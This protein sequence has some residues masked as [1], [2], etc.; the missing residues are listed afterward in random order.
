MEYTPTQVKNLITEWVRDRHMI[1][2]FMTVEGNVPSMISVPSV[3]G[4]IALYT[5]K[6]VLRSIQIYI[7]ADI[8]TGQAA[9]YSIA[10][11]VG[12]MDF[13]TASEFKTLLGIAIDIAGQLEDMFGLTRSFN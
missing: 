6:N 4:P 8:E 7:N 11:S 5:G 9:T 10:P 2:D 3:E 13:E 12:L 1:Q